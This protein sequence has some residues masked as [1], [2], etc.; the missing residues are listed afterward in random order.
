MYGSFQANRA[1]ESVAGRFDQM[2]AL[3]PAH[4][5]TEEAKENFTLRLSKKLRRL[6]KADQTAGYTIKSLAVRVY[7]LGGRNGG[8]TLFIMPKR[9]ATG[10]RV[11][12]YTI[13]VVCRQRRLSLKGV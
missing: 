1:E 6:F 5:T 8:P 9:P 4:T 13:F 3:S 12:L 10:P 7:I 11:A 2:H